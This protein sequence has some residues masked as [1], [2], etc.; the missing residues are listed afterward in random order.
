MI[1]FLFYLLSLFV[2]VEVTSACSEE[3]GYDAHTGYQTGKQN[4]DYV[5]SNMASLMSFW[6]LA[7]RMNAYLTDLEKCGGEMRETFPEYDLCRMSDQ[8]WVGLKGQDTVFRIITDDLALTT[9]T[10]EWKIIG[11]APPYE[12]TVTIVCSNLRSWNFSVATVIN[13]NWVSDAQ[14]KIDYNSEGIPRNFYDGDWVV[15]GAGRSLAEDASLLNF[16]IAES[17]IRFSDS[18]YLFDKGLLY[19]RLKDTFSRQEEIV[20]AEMK[21]LSDNNRSLQITYKGSVYSY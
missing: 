21:V 2:L 8:E 10:A 12:G 1:R 17:L 3:D 16:E 20:K 4:Y 11:Y 9:E 14:L 7:L 5:E 13:R 18:R 6:D 15:S 19:L